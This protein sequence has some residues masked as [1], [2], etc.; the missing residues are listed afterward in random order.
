ML[1][2]NTWKWS[3]CRSGKN[4]EPNLIIKKKKKQPK[5]K[6]NQNQA[7]LYNDDDWAIS[8]NFYQLY[9]SFCK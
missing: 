8:N 2:G 5:K 1:K 7:I 3:D 4:F 6:Q 9:C